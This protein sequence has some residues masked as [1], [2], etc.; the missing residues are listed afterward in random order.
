[1]KTVS[2]HKEYLWVKTYK[3]KKF[4]QE[5]FVQSRNQ[6]ITIKSF[7]LLYLIFIWTFLERLKFCA[8]THKKYFC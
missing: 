2:I 6:L 3:N 7:N 4:K 1:M 8:I 5:M